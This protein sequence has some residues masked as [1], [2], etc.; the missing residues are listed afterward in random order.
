MSMTQSYN[1]VQDQNDEW[2]VKI[3]TEVTLGRVQLELSI[4][5]LHLIMQVVAFMSDLMVQ[6]TVKRLQDIEKSID[7]EGVQKLAPNSN[8][9]SKQQFLKKLVEKIQTEAND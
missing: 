3:E 5:D 1:L 4:M 8:D 2:G 7:K 6:E 9:E